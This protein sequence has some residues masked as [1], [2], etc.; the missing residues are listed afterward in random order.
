MNDRRLF[1]I[2]KIIETPKEQD[3]KDYDGANLDRLRGLIHP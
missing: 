2:P 3:G 1:D